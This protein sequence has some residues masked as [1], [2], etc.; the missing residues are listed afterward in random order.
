MTGLFGV[1]G[2][3]FRKGIIVLA[4]DSAQWR[5]A[6]CGSGGVGEEHVYE[7]YDV[8]DARDSIGI[9]LIRRS[10]RVYFLTNLTCKIKVR[11]NSKVRY[12]WR[13][14][15]QHVKLILDTLST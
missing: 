5:E 10:S 6:S 8:P 1:G 3:G 14:C 13:R 4:K 11:Y 7:I 12:F 2:G 9:A 15:Q